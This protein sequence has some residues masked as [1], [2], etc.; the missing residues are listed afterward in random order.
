[1]RCVL[2]CVFLAVL[3]RARTDEGAFSTSSEEPLTESQCNG[4]QEHGCAAVDRGSRLFS[5][6][7]TAEEGIEGKEEGVQAA[8]DRDPLTAKNGDSPP[9]SQPSANK[10][11]RIKGGVYTM[12]TDKPIVP[13]DGEGPGRR[14]EISEFYMDMYEVSNAEFANFVKETGYVT[15][16]EK[17]G[18]SFV[19]EML[20]SNEVQS[21]I[22]QAV[23][24]AP[25]WLPVKGA[26]WMSPEGKGSNIKDRMDHP[27]VHISWNDA[28]AYCKWAGKRLPTEAEWEYAARGGLEDRLY[29]WGNNAN[30]R[31]EHWMNIWQG[32]FPHNNTA[33]DGYIGTA[34]VD[35]Y[36]ANKYGLHNMVGNVWEWTTDWWAVRHHKDFQKD[37]QGP[38]SGTDKVKKGGSYMCHPKFCYRYRC[39]ARSQNTPDSSA[40]NLGFRCAKSIDA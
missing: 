10:L 8:D 18:D 37:P 33:E 36:P 2:L 23:A 4:V 1:M 24:N 17:F 29:P 27:V 39:A 16:A 11:V 25:W 26:S 7:S 32:D 22:T 21:E 35:S 20:L 9:S 15:E 30:P 12:G 13:Q 19:L 28:V 3:L 5:K 38:P 34:P 6:R 14:V 40:S 31:G